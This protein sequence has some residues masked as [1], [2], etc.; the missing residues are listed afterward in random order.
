MLSAQL[1]EDLDDYGR[2]VES[3]EALV[4]DLE[5]EREQ[6]AWRV[7]VHDWAAKYARYVYSYSMACLWPVDVGSRRATDRGIA[8]RVS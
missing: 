5:R 4:E 7:V 3:L 6:V 2:A 8:S 1:S